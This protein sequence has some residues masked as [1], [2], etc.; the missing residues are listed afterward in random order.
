[1]TYRCPIEGK[2]FGEGTS[3]G[4]AMAHL[5]QAHPGIFVKLEYK[6]RNREFYL[7]YS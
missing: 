1:M 3:I 5:T 7:K 4:D 6:N 2:T